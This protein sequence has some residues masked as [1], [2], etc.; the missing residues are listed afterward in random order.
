MLPVAPDMTRAGGLALAICLAAA[1]LAAQPVPAA[2]AELTMQL[3]DD[4]PRL[5]MEG[6]I[7]FCYAQWGDYD[8]HQAF[9]AD[10]GYSH[11]EWG[12][13]H[14]YNK[15]ST[16]VLMSPDFFCDVSDMSIPQAEARDILMSV[17]AKAPGDTW[18]PGRTGAGCPDLGG[19]KGR[20]EVQS[21]GQDPVC[22]PTGDSAV[23]FWM[24]E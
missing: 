12:G 11:A 17:L 8:G 2:L 13:L 4:D 23:R 6:A 21:A 14:E 9:M 19:P 16:Q 24:A 22:Q 10:M 18:A 3:G 5:R 7:A 1:P 20:I 15:G